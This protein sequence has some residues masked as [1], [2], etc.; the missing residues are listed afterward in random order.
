[1]TTSPEK[2]L[3]NLSYKTTISSLTIAE[4]LQTTHEFIIDLTYEHINKLKEFGEITFEMD[5]SLNVEPTEIA[6]I[7]YYQTIVLMTQV[8]NSEIIQ[9][10]TSQIMTKLYQ[11]TKQHMVDNDT[12]HLTITALFKVRSFSA[13]KGFAIKLARKTVKECSRLEIQIRKVPDERYGEVNIY[14]KDVLEKCFDDL[15]FPPE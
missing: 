13:P 6:R 8:Q 1:M 4:E 7:N 14:P 2:S 10:F 11:L 3:I 12:G 5:L 9:K 15:L